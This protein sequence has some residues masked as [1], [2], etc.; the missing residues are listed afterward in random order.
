[1]ARR[2]SIVGLIAS[3]LVGVGVAEPNIAKAQSAADKATARTLATDGIQLFRQ[4]RFPEALD[5]LERAQSLFE[6]PV[7][8]LYIARCQVKV[9]RLVEAAEAYRKLIRTELSAQAPQ[10]FKDAVADGQKELPEIEPKI[11]SLRVE[12]VPANA[13]DLRLTIDGEA[14]STAVVGVDRPINPGSHVIEVASKGQSSVSRRV[15]V[16]IA[17]KQVV[18]LDLA[19]GSTQA[20]VGPAAAASGPTSGTDAPGVAATSDSD[21]SATK[22]GNRDVNRPGDAAEHASRRVKIVGGVDVSSAVPF[23]GKVDKLTGTGSADDRA[24]SGRFGPGVGL[25]LRLG[26]AIP[27]G[28]FA[29]TPLFYVNAHSHA[30]GPLYKTSA[31]QSYGLEIPGD[32]VITTSPTSTSVGLAVRFDT[33]P[34]RPFQ[35]GGFGEFGVMLREAYSTKGTLTAI[36][37]S[38]KCDFTED[39]VGVGARTRAGLLMPVSRVVSLIGSV[40]LSFGRISD[41][42]MTKKTCDSST[43]EAEFRPQSSVTVPADSRAW[44]AALGLGLGAEFGLGL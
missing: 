22:G 25:E 41:S 40:G 10:T 38:G 8:L 5:K 7:H 35:V 36:D 13:K 15:E 42:G 12:V 33:A 18:R 29:L 26:A 3:M 30:P 16:A 27:L 34:Q 32:S 44:H 19:T 11:P 1:M 23:T 4:D 14:V 24:L 2:A 39:F 9:H 43:L 21:A 17:S 28:Q 37:P 6:A 31:D 20:G